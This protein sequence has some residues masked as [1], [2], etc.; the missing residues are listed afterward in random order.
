[1]LLRVIS[2]VFP[3][4][5]IVMAGWWFGRRH[6]PDMVVANRLNMEMF[7]PALVFSA[8][9]DGHF[10]M[11]AHWAPAEAMATMVLG[12]GLIAW[13]IARLFGVHPKTL[14]PPMMFNNCGN[15][16]IPLSV[17]AFGPPILPAAVMLFLTSNLMHFSLGAW[18]LDHRQRAWMVWKVPVVLASVAGIA[19]S[20]GG[21]TLWPPL[22]TGIH[23]MGEISVPL[24]LFS[25]GV[26]VAEAPLEHLKLGIAAGLL[27]SF[28]GFILMWGCVQLFHL[29][30][31]TAGLVLLFGVLPPAVLNY[32]F[33]ER[34]QQ[35]PSKVASI[36]LIGN[37]LAVPILPIALA[38]VLSVEGLH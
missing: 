16:G 27:R 6:Q 3:V 22:Y 14:V 9:A 8:L 25:L 13:P 38:V 12:S 34:Y 36:V 30:G 31:P 17:L 10:D 20:F 26:K 35:E 33:S 18:L 37:L 32:M 23:M 5:M 24:M 1:M 11:H 2:I 7:I 19:L 21:L 29:E 4:F 28:L 15:L